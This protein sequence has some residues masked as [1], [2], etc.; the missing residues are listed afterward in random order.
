MG[1]PA[2]GWRVWEMHDTG[3][4]WWIVMSLGM[5]AFWA[6]VI[7]AIWRAAT[8][9]PGEHVES[10]RRETPVEILERRLA[11]GEITVGEYEEL[12]ET[13]EGRSRAPV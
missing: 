7:W 10:P 11:A 6:L 1:G 5:I 3:A 9:R 12:R 4:G 13:L 8:D 2:Y